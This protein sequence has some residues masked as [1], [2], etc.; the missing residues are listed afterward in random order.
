MLA[1]SGH[2]ENNLINYIEQVQIHFTSKFSI[3]NTFVPN[4]YHPHC[5]TS[6]K[7]RLSRL[8]IYSL[9]RRRERFSIITMHKFVLDPTSIPPLSPPLYNPR[10]KTRLTPILPPKE[11]P[12]W[13]RQARESSIFCIGPKLYNSLPPHLRELH[14]SISQ[15]KTALDKFLT[16]IP[17]CPGTSQNSLLS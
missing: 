9:Q 15:F 16:T 6:Y 1:S 13:V 12:L 14:L 11:A 17:D 7:D 3:F 5:N 2:L 4:S 10:T 8:H